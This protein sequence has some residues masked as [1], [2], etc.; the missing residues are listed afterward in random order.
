MNQSLAGRAILSAYL[1]A[2]VTSVNRYSTAVSSGDLN[3]AGLQAN[4]VLTYED[5]LV[6]LFQGDAV[7]T[8]RLLGSLQQDGIPNIQA[9]FADIVAFQQ[10]V[11]ANGLP[12]QMIQIL[13]QQ[14]LTAND[15][16]AIQNSFVNTQA[17]SI[18]G[19]LITSLQADA[20][21]SQTA[22][23]ALAQS[24]PAVPPVPPVIVV[25]G[26]TFAYD[27]TAHGATANASG[28]SWWAGVR[29]VRLHLHAWRLLASS[30]RGDLFGDGAVHEQ[31]SELHKCQQHWHD[32]NHSGDSDADSRFN[33]KHAVG[34]S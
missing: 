10:N 34:Q 14:G 22:S 32:H 5:A 17:A 28:V 13:L 9:S 31:R 15:I 6:L 20:A 16:Q 3:S 24:S 7:A 12:A 26:G 27:G 25:T 4:A 23:V 11:A 21:T 2:L 18:A 30:E 33:R 1:D 8:Q 29:F 19:G